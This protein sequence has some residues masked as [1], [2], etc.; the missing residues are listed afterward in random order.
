MGK[1]RTF[2]EKLTEFPKKYYSDAYINAPQNDDRFGEFVV[3]RKLLTKEKYE[4]IL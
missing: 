4:G 1:L 3:F 2:Y